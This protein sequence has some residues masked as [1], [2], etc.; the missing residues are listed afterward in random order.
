MNRKGAMLAVFGLIMSLAFAD[1]HA[2]DYRTDCLYPGDAESKCKAVC[3]THGGWNGNWSNSA[4]GSSCQYG[5]C[6]CNQ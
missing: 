1:V 3:A 2:K 5:I 6:G 4:L